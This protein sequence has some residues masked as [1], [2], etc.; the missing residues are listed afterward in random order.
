MNIDHK[1][2]NYFSAA[3][4][5]FL[6]P[7]L[8]ISI[9]NFHDWGDDFAQYLLQAKLISGSIAHLPVSS[10]ESY[11]PQQKGLLFS[12]ILAPFLNLGIGDVAGGKILIS[13]SLFFC[14][15]IFFTASKNKFHTVAAFIIAITFVYNYHI[16][17]LKDQILPDLL[18]TGITIA[19]IAFFLR[20]GKRY[21]LWSILLAVMLTGIKSA[22]FALVGAM[23]IA[24]LLHD[25]KWHIKLPNITILVAGSLFM[26]MWE[27]LATA[28]TTGTFWY[29]SITSNEWHLQQLSSNFITYKKAVEMYFEQELPMWLNHI[30]KYL[31]ITGITGGFLKNMLKKITLQEIYVVGYILLLLFYPYPHDP[32][33]LAIPLI[34]FFVWYILEFYSSAYQYFTKKSG[35]PITITISIILALSQLI[36][37]K[38]EIV[39]VR[40]Y[41]TNSDEN[42]ELLRFV[43]SNIP[44]NDTVSFAKPWALAYFTGRHCVPNEAQGKAKW[45]IIDPI[46][47][48]S[49]VNF[50]SSVNQEA[51][52][53]MQYV[54]LSSK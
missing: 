27:K 41:D 24:L 34:P 5:L 10:I 21:L 47:N 4:I 53:N 33:R 28:G 19:A 38:N 12:L 15:W 39:N 44:I 13:L 26:L 7:M 48:S 25:E 3:I 6:L 42:I 23:A 35:V 16:L 31:V 54:I 14:G 9:N 45:I 20:G 8:F 29:A 43:N 36:T 46:I 49:V 37:S 22:G 51:F 1:E 17:R 40:K 50:D 32:I 30:I 52:R 18:F 2:K 11:G